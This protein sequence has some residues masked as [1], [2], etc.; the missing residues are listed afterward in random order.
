MRP[1]VFVSRRLYWQMFD[2]PH[3][4]LVVSDNMPQWVGHLYWVDYWLADIRHW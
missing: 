1:T 3:G 2:R 4:E